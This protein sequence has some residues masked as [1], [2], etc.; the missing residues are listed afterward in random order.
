M[1]QAGGQAGQVGAR[2]GTGRRACG[3]GRLAAMRPGVM[4]AMEEWR[5]GGMPA[6]CRRHVQACLKRHQGG[7]WQVSS[8]GQGGSRPQAAGSPHL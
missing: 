6:W 5:H 7:S 1:G 4:A 2:R 3:A 8:T